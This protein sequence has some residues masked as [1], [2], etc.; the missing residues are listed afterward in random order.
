[1][2]VKPILLKAVIKPV[3]IKAVQ[4]QM[5]GLQHHNEELMTQ[6][7]HFNSMTDYRQNHVK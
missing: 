5:P 2:N 6:S 3:L 1:M 7:V 4:V